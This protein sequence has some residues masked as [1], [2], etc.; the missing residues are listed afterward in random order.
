MVTQLAP[1]AG[2]AAVDALPPPLAMR[3]G[4]SWTANLVLPAP[5]P[6]AQALRAP[7]LATDQ[8]R[9]L[10]RRALTRQVI[11]APASSSTGHQAANER[12]LQRLPR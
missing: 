10:L 9:L 2:A 1:W 3:P 7:L 11:G 8:D 4:E 12:W 6:S 5:P